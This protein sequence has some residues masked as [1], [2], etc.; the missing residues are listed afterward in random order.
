MLRQ[1][2]YDLLTVDGQ[3]AALG[4]NAAA[5]FGAA[6]DSPP[7]ERFMVLR[8][9]TAGPRLGRDTTV[10]RTVLAVWAYDRERDYDAIAGALARV[11]GILLPVTG[12]HGDGFIID[13]EDNGTSDD[14]YDP[15]Y[16]AVTRFWAF[17]ITASEN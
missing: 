13:V 8:W 16:E 3:L 2:V 10:R 7:S 12:S 4:Y 15:V 5:I 14:L 9:G 6:P 11:C 1:K 17:T